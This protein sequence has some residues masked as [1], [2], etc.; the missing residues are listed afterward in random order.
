MHACSSY[1]MSTSVYIYIVALEH[2]C[3][4]PMQLDSAR[5]RKS[6][7]VMLSPVRIDGLGTRLTLRCTI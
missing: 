3:P 6:S 4:A 7:D 1:I 5:G 2:P